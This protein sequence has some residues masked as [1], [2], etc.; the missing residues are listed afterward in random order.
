MMLGLDEAEGELRSGMCLR[1]AADSSP[2][3]TTV[4]LS[5]VQLP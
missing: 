4:P 5:R 1:S 2:R 3:S